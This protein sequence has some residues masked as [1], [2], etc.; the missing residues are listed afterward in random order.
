M[1]FD[2]ANDQ[3]YEAICSVPSH[4][5]NFHLQIV[6]AV[7]QFSS[8]SLLDNIR[9]K[10]LDS[11][12]KF[13]NYS[14][15]NT[16]VYWE[17]GYAIA[18]GKICIL[19]DKE[20]PG[21]GLLSGDQV[22]LFKDTS[23]RLS[24]LSKRLAVAIS[25]IISNQENNLW[26]IP[27]VKFF[28]DRASARFPKLILRTAEKI[29]IFQTNL[30]SVAA[31]LLDPIISSLKEH[32]SLKV[33]F[34]TLDPDSP[35]SIYRSRQLGV[36]LSAYRNEL[37]NSIAIIQSRIDELK[38]RFKLKIYDDFP[39]KICYRFDDKIFFSIVS[40]STRSRS[41]PVFF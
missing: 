28:P 33:R 39:T 31:M 22:I 26:E 5:D 3:T 23:R 4:I 12:I 32:G 40:R 41:N 30:S 18:L 9:R 35:F 11:E 25:N 16:N 8:T 21:T 17:Y 36:D 29:D 14:N 7:E 19:I 10:I 13:I 27:Q 34:L 1:P 6:H 2:C 15:K 24:E 20:K 38:G 37:I